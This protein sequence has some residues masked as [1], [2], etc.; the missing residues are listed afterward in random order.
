MK[1]IALLTL[2]V[3]FTG[4]GWAGTI[5][6]D[7]LIGVP[8][9]IYLPSQYDQREA[10]RFPVLYLHHG[11]FGNENDWTEQGA[12]LSIM[13]SLLRIGAIQEWVVIMPD[14]CPG[15][16]TFEEEKAN[17]TTGE[18]ENNFARFMDEAEHRY[19]IF[20]TPSRRAVAGLSMGGY[21]TMRVASVLSG[22]FAYV[23]MFS[24]ATF[25]HNAPT[26]YKLFWIGIGKDDFLYESL[27]E[28]RHWLEANHI[29]YTYYQSEGGHDWPNWRDYICRFL[30]HIS[31]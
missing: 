18:W 3:L 26:D 10:E 8:C 23:G 27:Q 24:P 4:L 5:I 12:L 17:A 30:Q 21:H 31:R 29:E 25:V 28:Y 1:K 9:R 13:D 14:N 20:D 11:M 7:T 2:L 22:Q 19:R 15:R 16:P 6:R